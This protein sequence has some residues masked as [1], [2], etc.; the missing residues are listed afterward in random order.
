YLAHCDP[1]PPL[2]RRIR[3]QRIRDHALVT[4]PCRWARCLH[5]FLGTRRLQPQLRLLVCVALLAALLPLY[6]SGFDPGHFSFAGA[7]PA[8]AAL[9]VV[10]IVC[11]I[12]A[13]WL[14]KFHRLAALILLSGAG[15]AT[16]ITFAW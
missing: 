13:A 12:A 8:F 14:A 7:D 2:F 10:G 5:A 6:R 1:D 11:A 16:C 4:V 15:L 3:R 9:W